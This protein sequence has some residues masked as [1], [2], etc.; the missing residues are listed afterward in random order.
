MDEQ[1]SV[2]NLRDFIPNS[3]DDI[4]RAHRDE[5]RLEWATNE[6]L[7]RRKA[8]LQRVDATVRGTICNWNVLMFHLT[9]QG[10]ATS[11]PFIVGTVQDTRQPWITSAVEAVDLAAGLVKTKNSLYRVVGPRE[12]EPDTHTLIHICVWL[13]DRGLGPYFGVPGFFY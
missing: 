5:C 2:T 10:R 7:E 11:A 9:L 4:V 12:P 6:E 3:V 1:S 8:D 13:N